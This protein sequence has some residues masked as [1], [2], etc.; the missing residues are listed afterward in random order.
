M[1]LRDFAIRLLE[2]AVAEGH[3]SREDLNYLATGVIAQ[4]GD[5]APLVALYVLQPEVTPS[6]VV[7]LCK[8]IID[9]NPLDDPMWDADNVLAP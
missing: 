9:V 5:Y 7:R 8:W 4:C 2:R 6:Q 1:T 3:T